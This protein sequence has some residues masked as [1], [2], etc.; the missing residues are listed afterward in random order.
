[1]VL[2]PPEG[3]TLLHPPCLCIQCSPLQEQESPLSRAQPQPLCLKGV[4]P[5]EVV[6]A[7]PTVM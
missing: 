4:C 3:A 6:Q 2:L 1:M 7:S 5:R